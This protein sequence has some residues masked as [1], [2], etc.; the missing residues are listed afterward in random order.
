MSCQATRLENNPWEY[1]RVKRRLHLQ[2]V[3][4]MWK[5]RGQILRIKLQMANTNEISINRDCL[6]RILFFASARDKEVF[7]KNHESLHRLHSH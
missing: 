4:K 2:R 1:A 5:I 6:L 7:K 3:P